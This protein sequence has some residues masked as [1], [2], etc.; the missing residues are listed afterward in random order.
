MSFTYRAGKITARSARR[1]DSMSSAPALSMTQRD[2]ERVVA[3]ALQTAFGFGRRAARALAD[4][5]N[6]NDRTA[7]GWLTGESTP[8]FVH[9]LRLIATV[10]AFAGEVRRLTG[11]HADM[12]PAF[13]R[14]FIRLVQTYG[15][16]TQ[17]AEILATLD[18]G[19][20]PAMAHTRSAT[21]EQ[22]DQTAPGP[23]G[24]VGEE[25]A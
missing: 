6:C 7:L 8:G 16:W 13:Q 4:A 3:H 22:E 18:R 12:D 21:A 14:D 23:G 15:D 17:N 9:T 25:K 19:D 10:P 24:E 2:G 1:S 20:V 11:M 5:A